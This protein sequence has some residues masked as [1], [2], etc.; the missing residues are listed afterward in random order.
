MDSVHFELFFIYLVFYNHFLNILL[1]VFRA[2]DDL[3]KKKW[4]SEAKI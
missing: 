3:D 1:D 2:E 4:N